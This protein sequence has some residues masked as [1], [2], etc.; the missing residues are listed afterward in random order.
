MV[1]ISIQ[2]YLYSPKSHQQLPQKALQKQQIHEQ[3]VQD[4]THSPP[5]TLHQDKDKLKKKRETTE[6]RTGRDIE[7]SRTVIDK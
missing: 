3:T 6:G 7:V 4:N 5:Q 2:F 1:K